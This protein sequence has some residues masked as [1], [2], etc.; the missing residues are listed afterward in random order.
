[1]SKRSAP[2]LDGECSLVALLISAIGCTIPVN[3][4]ASRF[5]FL[6]QKGISAQLRRRGCV[7]SSINRPL[8]VYAPPVHPGEVIASVANCVTSADNHCLTGSCME[9]GD[10][11]SSCTTPRYEDCDVEHVVSV[12]V[13]LEQKR[14]Q[15]SRK[16]VVLDELRALKDSDC[17]S[18]NVLHLLPRRLLS[19]GVLGDKCAKKQNGPESHAS[20]ARAPAASASRCFKL[21]H[22]LKDRTVYECVNSMILTGLMLAE[23]GP[24]R[25]RKW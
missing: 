5:E 8:R 19:H 21:A 7:H 23:P 12:E 2:S 6:N 16:Q 22:C 11:P 4:C 3:Y 9:D 17:P 25:P 18:R 20:N 14:I 24:E 1:M 10:A 15:P 13:A